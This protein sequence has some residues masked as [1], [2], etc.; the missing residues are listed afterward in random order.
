MPSKIL[1][2]TTHPIQAT[3]AMA[4]ALMVTTTRPTAGTQLH[5]TVVPTLIPSTMSSKTGLFMVPRVGL[6]GRKCAYALR[7]REWGLWCSIKALGQFEVSS[8]SQPRRLKLCAACEEFRGTLGQVGMIFCEIFVSFKAQGKYILSKAPCCLVF[9]HRDTISNNGTCYGQ[10]FASLLLA[11]TCPW[12][13]DFVSFT[14]IF[15][16]QVNFFQPW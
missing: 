15:S 14:L 2:P 9:N 7:C 13:S 3:P 8:F 1:I 5:P 6:E 11:Y 12:V 16:T 10:R 4:E